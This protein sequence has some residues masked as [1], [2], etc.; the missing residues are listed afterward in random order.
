MQLNPGSLAG[1]S[2]LWAGPKGGSRGIVRINPVRQKGYKGPVDWVDPKGSTG[3][4]R[5]PKTEKAGQFTRRRVLLGLS[6]PPES[7]CR[8]S[9]LPARPLQSV[10]IGSQPPLCGLGYG[11]DVAK[12]PCV[13][14]DTPKSPGHRVV[15]DTRRQSRIG[16]CVRRLWQIA[17]GSQTHRSRDKVI[18]KPVEGLS[19][20]PLEHAGQDNEPQAAI[21]GHLARKRDRLSRNDAAACLFGRQPSRR[22]R[23]VI[24]R[25]S[26]RVCQ[27]VPNRRV[28][29]TCNREHVGDPGL[30]PEETPPHGLQGQ[31]C[32]CQDLRQ[33]GQVVNGVNPGGRCIRVERQPT[34]G[35]QN[36][37][38]TVAVRIRRSGEPPFAN[39]PL[40]NLVDLRHR[41]SPAQP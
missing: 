13:P 34:D 29:S 2:H 7:A 41:V 28:C 32:G 9:R 33:T 18:E 36:D 39:T 4:T 1:V 8:L 22:Q 17:D 10:G 11:R 20:N 3:V 21:G 12:Q 24:R 26:G 15:D 31:G 40:Q 38:L 30:K 14:T 27:E 37:P 19:Q 16:G 25:Q 6:V 35:T 5:M 23:M